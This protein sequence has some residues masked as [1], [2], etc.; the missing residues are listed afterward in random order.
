MDEEKVKRAAG[1]VGKLAAAGS[2]VAGCLVWG[3]DGRL[4]QVKIGGLALWD[5]ARRDARRAR[6][7][8]K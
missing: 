3:E 2:A 1:V 8:G 5:R 4:S 6:R 7:A